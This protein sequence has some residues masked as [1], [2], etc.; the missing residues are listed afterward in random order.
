MGRN[1]QEQELP[2]LVRQRLLDGDPYLHI[3]GT[4]LESL[5]LDEQIEK[6]RGIS[7]G[8]GRLALSNA[9]STSDVWVLDSRTS[10]SA[11]LIEAHTDNP[12]KSE[13]EDV[14]A[15]W[16][17]RSSPQG[18]Q[19]VLTP[20][21]R[22]MELGDQSGRLADGL[23]KARSLPV[24]FTHGEES[25]N[26]PVVDVVG[27]TIRYDA[28]YMDVPDA[29]LKHLFE[30]AVKVGDIIELAPGDV[31]FFNNKTTVHAR[32]PYSDPNRLSIRTRINL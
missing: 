28:K 27:H 22:I 3:S 5:A 13:P 9:D 18:G 10:P 26:G 15:F 4:G 2:S 19:N 24:T 29:E 6:I 14:V 1:V 21:D 25:W 31:L 12:F 17:V 20:L 30:E 8:I 11:R 7:Q 16:S 23:E 32:L